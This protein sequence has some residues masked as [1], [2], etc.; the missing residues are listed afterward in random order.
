MCLM[1]R[2]VFN[3]DISYSSSSL[4]L[5]LPCS[6]V[7]HSVWFISIHWSKEF[8][9]RNIWE[10]LNRLILAFPNANTPTVSVLSTLATLRDMGAIEFVSRGRYLL[11][12]EGKK[13]LEKIVT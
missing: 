12:P 11:A 13:I 3:E 7:I 6:W 9:S 8:T 4:S 5:Q 2:N 10:Y 1:K